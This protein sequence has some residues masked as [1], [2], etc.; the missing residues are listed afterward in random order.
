MQGGPAEGPWLSD[1]HRGEWALAGLAQELDTRVVVLEGGRRLLGVTLQSPK[2]R[3]V[4][5]SDRVVGTPL[6]RAVLAHELAH[7][8]R[9]DRV[10]FCMPETGTEAGERR[11]WRLGARLAVSVDQARCIGDGRASPEE[12]ADYDG[13]P[14]LL[15]ALRCAELRRPSDR[16]P[17]GEVQRCDRVGLAMRAWLSYLKRTAALL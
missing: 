16:G 13:V 15:V 6:E 7:V 14:S 9:G 1:W 2:T 12:V 3:L 10:A 5:L 8:A 11:A 17:L 4:S